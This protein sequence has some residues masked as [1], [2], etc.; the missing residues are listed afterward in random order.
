[1]IW[2]QYSLETRGGKP[3]EDLVNEVYQ[4]LQSVDGMTMIRDE[5]YSDPVFS[6]KIDDKIQ[7]LFVI[8][9]RDVGL[10]IAFTVD[11]VKR[12]QH[13]L[14]ESIANQLNDLHYRT[15]FIMCSDGILYARLFVQFFDG[16]SSDYVMKSIGT[17]LRGLNHYYW[18]RKSGPLDDEYSDLNDVYYHLRPNY[19]EDE[20]FGYEEICYHLPESM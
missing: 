10:E 18:S 6:Y 11:T 15:T 1:M 8:K 17:T 16:I 3:I 5:S 14:M 20:P 13:G 4:K 19:E 7:T 2:D 12:W 9:V